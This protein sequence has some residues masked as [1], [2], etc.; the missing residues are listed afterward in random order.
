M[1]DIGSPRASSS[2][3]GAR[4]VLDGAKGV[5]IFDLDGTISHRDLFLVFLREAARR[6]GPA[7]PMRTALLPLHTLNYGLKRMT[8]TALKIAYLDAILGNRERVTLM[9]ISDEF[10]KRCLARE[11]KR[12]ALKAMER[13]RQAGDAL[14]LASASLD[15][16]VEPIGAL[17]G[18]D[19]VI[20][21]R[22]AWTAEGR[23]AGSLDGNNL[24]GAPKLAAVRDLMS[25][26]FQT[27]QDFVAYSDHESDVPLLAAA[28]T[29]VAVDPTR[30][31]REEARKRGWPIVDWRSSPG[32][33]LRHGDDASRPG[34]PARLM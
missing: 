5:A 19:A 32:A 2:L 1:N 21:T 9:Q 27:A 14:V 16:Y 22:V 26:R 18:F 30:K 34:W 7:R 25:Q 31:L 8:N 24:R 29:A 10:A 23:I 13:H 15:L 12:D 33:S 3:F 11:I 20:S 17:L 6:L 4:G 28:G